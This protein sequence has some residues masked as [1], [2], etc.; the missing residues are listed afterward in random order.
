MEPFSKYILTSMAFFLCAVFCVP[1]S[2]AVD[3]AKRQAHSTDY[4]REMPSAER[5]MADFRAEGLLGTALDTAMRQ[6]TAL[7]RLITMITLQQEGGEFLGKPT[8]EEQALKRS[9]YD[10]IHSQ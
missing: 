8:A 9:Y 5:V 7:R 1:Q 10:A 4:L 6:I 2:F 3:P